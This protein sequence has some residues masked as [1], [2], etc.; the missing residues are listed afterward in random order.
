MDAPNKT[1]PT[2]EFSVHAFIPALCFDNP[3]SSHLF[4]MSRQNP[5][6]PAKVRTSENGVRWLITRVNGRRF[7]WPL[8]A[9]QHMIDRDTLRVYVDNVE[10]D[11]TKRL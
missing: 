7:G 1:E 11:D 6:F 10:Q 9:V 2:V 3:R 5:R 8:K 4:V